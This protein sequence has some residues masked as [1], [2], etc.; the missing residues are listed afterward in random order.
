MGNDDKFVHDVVSAARDFS[1][2]FIV[3][4]CTPVPLMTGADMDA[5]RR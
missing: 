4:L 3:I 2:K 5:W 1:P